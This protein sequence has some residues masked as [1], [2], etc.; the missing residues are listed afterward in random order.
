ME[1]PIERSAQQLFL[2]IRVRACRAPALFGNKLQVPVIFA[3]VLSSGHRMSK[4]ART[5]VWRSSFLIEAPQ[6][7]QDEEHHDGT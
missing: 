2:V 4:S 5:E 7:T 3:N 6:L 1:T